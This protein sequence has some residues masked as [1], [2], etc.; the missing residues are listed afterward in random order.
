MDS[1]AERT[2][3]TSRIIRH[4]GIQLGDVKQAAALYAEVE[5]T[6]R[7][8]GLTA[9]NKSALRQAAMAIGD[10]HLIAQQFDAAADCYRT[11]ESL[12]QP[13]VPEAVRVAKIGAYRESIAQAIERGRTDDALVVVR[14]WR[15]QFPES[16]L[17]GRPLFWLGR[18]AME[19]NH[20]ERAVQPLTLA[21]ARGEGTS[22]EAEA[23][24]HLAQAQN[25]LGYKDASRDT[26]QKLIQTGMSSKFRDK[27]LAA[28]K[29]SP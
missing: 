7:E 4:L 20:P 13:L 10:V 16:L 1:S 28:L 2:A 29:E 17:T 12:S 24:W 8:A 6:A 22:F 9:S 25:Q 5:K 26:L 18:I 3:I 11:A 19:Q 27:A 15:E 21:L 14:R 23:Y